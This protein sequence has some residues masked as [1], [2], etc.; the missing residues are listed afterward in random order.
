[1]MF[2]KAWEDVKMYVLK[3]DSQSCVCVCVCVCHQHDAAAA[4]EDGRQ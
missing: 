4:V 3:C 1:M 2:M